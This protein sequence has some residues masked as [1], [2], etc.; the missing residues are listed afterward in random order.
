MLYIVHTTGKCNLRCRYCGGSFPQELVPWSPRYDPRLLKELVESDPDAILA[1]YGGEPLLNA[2]FIAWA[3]DNIEAHHYVVQTNGT[4]NHLLPDEYW[5]RF[6]TVLLSIDGVE[7]LT[8]KY[9]GH[10]IYRRVVAEA[11][12]LRSIGY[13]GDLIARMAVTEDSDI[14]RDVK[15][16]LSLGP[17]S[18]VHWQ[19]DVVWS[20]RWHDFPA[21]RDGS[22]L[23]G[24]ERLAG[25]W[26]DAM[27]RGE[28]W[29]IAP[30]KAVVSQILWGVYE[31]MPCGAG[32]DAVAILTDGRIVACPIAVSEGW[33]QLG[34]LGE[35]GPGD[36]RD[37]VRVGEPCTSC[38]YYPVCGGRCL[39]AYMERYWGEEGFR[40]V[41]K[42]TQGFI[43]VML[44]A[45]VE[46]RRLVDGGV[47]DK[48]ML[49]YP[50]FNNTVE[51]IP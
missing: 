32:R 3:L 49:Y 36:L 28:V 8:D 9:R 27:A 31:G 35:V 38:P 11:R 18:H 22:Y 19:L 30:F 12:R 23:P 21:W 16:L 5:L 50:P 47:V 39:Y 44:R 6:D 48:D 7:W 41:C 46:A 33:A 2:P 34:R 1:F 14:Y 15:H 51:V 37:R 17:F 42:A 4:L 26:L 13:K 40:E 24:I 29:G 25:E 43:D 10:G 45:A 20:D